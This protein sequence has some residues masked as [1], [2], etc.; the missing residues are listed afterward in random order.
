MSLVE[1][2]LSLQCQR[3]STLCTK[4]DVS[5]AP[6]LSRWFR[7]QFPSN[8]K[9]QNADAKPKLTCPPFSSNHEALTSCLSRRRLSSN[10]P[11]LSFSPSSP[12]SSTSSSSSA[13][14]TPIHSLGT[15]QGTL[16]PTPAA[17]FN[18]PGAL[19]PVSS[20]HSSLVKWLQFL[21]NRSYSRPMNF[22]AVRWMMASI[23]AG[24]KNDIPCRML[25]R[26]TAP[27]GV[28]RGG[29]W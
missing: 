18:H 17:L 26:K 13:S 23:S 5:S 7:R 8:S 10:I 25:Q 3:M 2:H 16:T 1:A 12:S 14:G 6:N 21:L 9:H 11:S 27:G 22:A 24:G 29:V 19:L 28:A 20:K 15:T 4:L